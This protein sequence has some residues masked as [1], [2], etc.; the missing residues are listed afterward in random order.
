MGASPFFGLDI[1]LRGLQASRT[2]LDVI[3]HNVSN[4]NTPGY[5]RQEIHLSPTD[6]FTV[7]SFW[8]PMDVG[9][10]GTGV[11]V[12]SIE[13]MRD[14]SIERQIRTSTYLLKEYEAREGVFQRL[15]AI[16]NE[17]GAV[18][19]SSLINDFF[20][21]FQELSASPESMVVRAQVKQN[22]E[23][24]SEYFNRLAQELSSLREDTDDNIRVV[25][26]GINTILRQLGKTNE[27]LRGVTASGDN[28]NDLLDERD[29]LLEE[30]SE[31]IDIG[32]VES[33]DGTVNVY[34]GGRVVVQDE[35]VTELAVVDDINN[36]YYASIK[37]E[38][39]LLGSDVA[40]GSGE[41][42]GLIDLR[43]NTEFGIVSYQNDLDDLS[44]YITS[45]VNT[46]HQQGY[47]LLNEGNNH[48]FFAAPA[49]TNTALNMSL[50]AWILDP[51]RGLSRIAASTN[52]TGVPGAGLSGDGS[53]ALAIAQIQNST[54]SQLGGST[55]NEYYD[56]M[57]SQLG[58]YSQE[59]SNK[60]GNQ[61]FLLNQL[62]NFRD[63][64]SGVSLDEEAAKM[65]MYENSLNAAAQVIH[66]IDEVYDTL[67]GLID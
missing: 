23:S 59:E 31:Y 6:P 40:V 56:T 49:A 27:L 36:N 29:R 12:D 38:N 44:Y 61:D 53:N 30:L 65:M 17:P 57:I 32:V 28:P 21:S 20:N 54:I 16:F 47:G 24:L 48:N 25:V 18:G 64:V 45:Y 37:M 43:D 42:K 62:Y 4:A 52:S 58:V 60:V 9:Q 2:A 10:V 11:K 1:A 63:S 5:S 13:R 41:L 7:P 26:S 67:I 39:D 55:F 33:T 35:I 19:L 15:E 3:S 50:D 46:Q 8:R 14:Q 34:M 66:V 22:G 51:T